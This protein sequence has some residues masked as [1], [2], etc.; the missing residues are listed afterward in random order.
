[1]STEKDIQSF[2]EKLEAVT[3]WPTL[4]MFKFIVKAEQE[5]ELKEVFKNHEVG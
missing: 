2:R 3:E 5:N 1:M 4:Y